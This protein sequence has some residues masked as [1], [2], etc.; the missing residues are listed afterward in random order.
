MR[1]AALEVAELVG[2]GLLRLFNRLGYGRGGR[3]DDW[4]GEGLRRWL[5][6][7]SGDRLHGRLRGA[8]R[9]RLSNWLRNRLNGWQRRDFFDG[10]GGRL[11]R[12]FGGGQGFFVDLVGHSGLPSILPRVGRGPHWI[13]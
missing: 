13:H 5:D 2:K 8:L 7:R 10:L 1:V 9:D 12:G 11:R 6:D 4:G 3:L